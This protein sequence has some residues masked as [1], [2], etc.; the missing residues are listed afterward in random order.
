MGILYCE[1]GNIVIWLTEREG[2]LVFQVQVWEASL[3]FSLVLL[4]MQMGKNSLLS[5]LLVNME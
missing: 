2:F 4:I 3:D 1:N 5:K